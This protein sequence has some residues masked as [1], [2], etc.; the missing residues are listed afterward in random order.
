MRDIEV[1][2]DSSPWFI[3]LCLAAGALYAYL[4]YQKRGPWTTN[5]NRFLAVLRFALASMVFLLLLGPLVRQ[6]KNVTEDPTIVFAI[7]NSLSIAESLDSATVE[8]ILDSLG[9]IDSKL[10]AKNYSTDIQT[11]NGAENAFGGIRFDSR[12]TNLDQL[13]TNIRNNY[14]GRKLAGVV[15]VSDGIYNIGA[16]PTYKPFS[17]NVFT[18]GIGDTLPKSDVNLR[19]L[20]YNKIAYQGNKF[21]VVAELIS[22]GY[23]GQMVSV[24]VWEGSEVVDKKTVRLEG[25]NQT[26]RVEFQI[27]AKDKGMQHYVVKAARKEGEFTYVNNENHAYIDI[28]EGK[29]K[30]LIAA[31]APHPDIKAIRSAVESNQNYEV[32]LF[33]PGI[34]KNE[35]DPLKASAQ[36]YD[37]VIYHQAPD[38][39]NSLG[40]LMSH[41][42][43]MDVPSWYIVGA[44]TDLKRLQMVSGMIVISSLN[45]QKD[46][47]TPVL[48]ETFS[49]FQMGDGLQELLSIYPPV[50]VPFAKWELNGS[51]ENILFQKVGS[52]AT[53]K[54]LLAV[55]EENNRKTALLLGEGIWRWR[56][57]EYAK[58]E[59]H[60][61]FDELI[62]KLVQFLSTREDK[63]KFR[64]YPIRNE[65]LDNEPVV[66]ETEAYNDIYEKIFGQ[67][68]ELTVINEKNEKRSFTYVTNPNNTRYR[69]SGLE[70][71]LYKYAAS[72]TINGEKAESAGQFTV[73]QLQ[74]ESIN[75]TANFDLLRS[76]A[77]Q[78]NGEF[79][80]AGQLRQLEEDLLQ[81]E[82]QGAIYTSERFLPII[83]MTWIF[84]LLLTLV[85]LEWFLRRYYNSY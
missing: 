79:Y 26:Q 77:T 47:V 75:L 67:T 50:A 9:K 20:Y 61:I 38:S 46:F 69:I 76:I 40:Q 16:S 70:N 24:E 39:Q 55:N 44:Q 18:V 54:P 83:N 31:P 28:I 53:N 14:E 59:S 81:R 65:Y 71:G 5:V 57:Q 73:K 33:I 15:L 84:F 22:N 13:L 49:R 1:L 23:N 56:L 60:E 82:L 74:V 17:F 19:A 52:I 37:M 66:F 63:R 8:K 3:L 25:D 51:A 30:I 34:T 6:V 42:G 10:R 27:E 11:F 80:K 64:V 85:S 78:T 41:L 68:V 35:Q 29:Q 32:D 2:F 45:N 7:D 58:Q 36:T 62:V 12:S 43:K 21:P 72:T 4:L 48:N